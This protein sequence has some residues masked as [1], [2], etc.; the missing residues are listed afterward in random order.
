MPIH[1]TTAEVAERLGLTPAAVS[2]RV[3]HGQLTPAAKAPGVRGAYLFDPD[4]VDR[5]LEQRKAS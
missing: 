5:L 3:R 1:L 2:Y 4:E